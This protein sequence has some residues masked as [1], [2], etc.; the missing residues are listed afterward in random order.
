MA[1]PSNALGIERRNRALAV[2]SDQ[3][4]ELAVTLLVRAGP[5]A[6]ASAVL[7]KQLATL[8]AALG[9]SVESYTV[10]TVDLAIARPNDSGT[11]R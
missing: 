11:T 1:F 10:R 2:P 3:L 7:L 9:L 5:R 4:L 8:V 6:R